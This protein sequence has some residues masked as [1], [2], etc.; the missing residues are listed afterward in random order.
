[1]N[2][3]NANEADV[4][5]LADL[6]KDTIESAR[7]YPGQEILGEHEGQAIRVENLLGFTAIR[8]GGFTAYPAIWGQDFAMAYWGETL[9]Y[10]HP[11]FGSPP[12]DENPRA[13]LARLGATRAERLTKAPTDR[14]KGFLDAVETLWAE[15]DYDD[16]R[17]AYMEAGSGWVP[18][19][20]ITTAWV[21]SRSSGSD[22]AKA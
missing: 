21:R 8:P 9:C 4:R 5:F 6:T 2:V 18:F 11:L 12:D 1:M 20:T 7:V 15:G 19:C 22:S 13:V 14:E 16:R 10:N 3:K 17:V